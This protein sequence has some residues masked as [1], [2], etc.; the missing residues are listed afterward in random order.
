M[1]QVK[2][3]GVEELRG[4]LH[5]Q[6]KNQMPFALA[7]GLN[8]VAFEIRSVEIELIKTTFDRPKPQTARNVFVKKA[9]KA[10]PRA[11]V[12]FDQIYNKGI[13]EY[14]EANIDGGPRKMKPSER[15]LGRFYVPSAGAK[16]D[17]Y[18]NM[19]GGQITQILSHLGRFGEVAGYNM[20][21]T[22]ASKLRRSGSKKGT[23][24]FMVTTKTGG[25][26]PG[27]YQRVQSG[28]G[29]GGKTA[30]NLPAGSFQ[31][32]ATRGRFSSAIRS[33]GVMPV[34]LF[35][36]APPKYKGVWPFYKAAQTVVDTKLVPYLERA[37]DRALATAR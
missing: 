1:F 4:Y 19:Q 28:V 26:A 25:L 36:K 23:E 13:D 29:F 22:L 12:L 24:Y 2:I 21:Q 6:A 9:T 14:M 33:R 18:G 20:N 3:E 5:A 31:K 37:I 11:L 16:M 8:D 34:V 35:T 32:G 27:I 17:A 10:T 15:R 7:T 30:K